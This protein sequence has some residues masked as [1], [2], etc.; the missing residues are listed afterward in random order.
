MFLRGRAHRARY[1]VPDLKKS[2]R[3]NQSLKHKL[4]LPCIPLRFVMWNP[5]RTHLFL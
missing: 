2:D 5:G 3:A 1:C 4:P